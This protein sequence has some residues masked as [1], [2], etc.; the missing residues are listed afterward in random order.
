MQMCLEGVSTRKVK[1]ITVSL[2]GTSVSKCLVSQLADQL[3]AELE[4]WRSQPLEGGDCPY[5]F[6]DA[7]YERVRVA[8]G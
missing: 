1:D 2:C 7:R 3:D 6:V 5:L 8:I 4:A